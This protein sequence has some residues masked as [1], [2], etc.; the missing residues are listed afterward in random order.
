MK[1]SIPKDKITATDAERIKG[2]ATRITF[3]LADC[4]PEI[5][6]TIDGHPVKITRIKGFQAKKARDIAYDMI[7]DFLLRGY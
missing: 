2:L 4:G 3:K 7:E 6:T 5:D 1:P